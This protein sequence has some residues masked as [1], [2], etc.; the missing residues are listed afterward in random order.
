MAA[1]PKFTDQYAMLDTNT[2]PYYPYYDEAFYQKEI[3]LIFKK[4]WLF[5]GRDVDVP[6]VG[7]YVVREFP[8]LKTSVI[9]VR[10]KD[11]SIGAFHNVCA[12]R[13]NRLEIADC[14]SKNRFVC[15]FHGWAFD[16]NGQLKHV[17]DEEAFFNLDK[18][19]RGL[20]SVPIQ[21]WL[22]MLFVNFSSETP[23]PL[24]A[25]LGEL[26]HA[27]DGYP[28]PQMA[29]MLKIRTEVNANWKMVMDA[30][31]EGYH[32]VQL[33]GQSAGD[34]FMNKDNPFGHLNSVRLYDRHKSL[35]MFGNPQQTATAA[36]ALELKYQQMATYAPIQ[37]D[38]YNEAHESRWENFP[39][40]VNPDRRD[41]WAFDIHLLF[42]NCSF[43]TANGWS[44]N[45]CYWPVSAEKSIIEATVYAFEPT[46]VAGYIGFEHTKAMI[47]DVALEDLSTVERAQ[48]NMHSGAF[49]S[50]VL[51]DM[52]VVVRHSHYVIRNLIEQGA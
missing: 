10:Q 30:F 21:S 2:V 8:T 5:A 39:K 31:L 46:T 49:D 45:Q 20:K 22:G 28:L 40:G 43:Y 44:V 24:H 47:F 27:F 6:K 23:E 51:S 17:P 29:T 19:S 14:G 34:A 3:D 26:N 38:R 50:M 12:H 41:D 11:G 7:D 18:S 32:V 9:I 13:G 25:W 4:N 36:A 35:S 37:G 1:V 33:H 15:S 48:A 16:I 52:E 42:P